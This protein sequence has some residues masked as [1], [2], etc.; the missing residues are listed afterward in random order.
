MA[1]TV[2]EICRKLDLMDDM[3]QLVFFPHSAILAPGHNFNGFK[4]KE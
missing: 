2:T 4:D 1:P 3:Y